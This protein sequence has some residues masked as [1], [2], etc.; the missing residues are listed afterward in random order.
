MNVFRHRTRIVGFTL[1]PLFQESPDINGCAINAR[2]FPHTKYLM[3]NSDT[4]RDTGS[5]H[6]RVIRGRQK[7]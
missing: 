4:A 1:A 7:A 2:F 5:A 3:G 6:K